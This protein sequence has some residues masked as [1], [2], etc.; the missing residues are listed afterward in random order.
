M[1][2]KSHYKRVQVSFWVSVVWVNSTG[3]CRNGTI[4]NVFGAEQSCRMWKTEIC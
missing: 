2:S 3:L 1:H 4:I